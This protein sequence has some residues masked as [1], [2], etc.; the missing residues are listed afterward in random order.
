MCK[1]FLNDFFN[2][3]CVRNSKLKI[4]TMKTYIVIFAAQTRLEVD[5]TQHQRKL[6]PGVDAGISLLM[7]P[8]I[9]LILKYPGFTISSKT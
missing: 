6:N 7:S 4:Q 3:I 2:M 1:Q 9:Q 8:S 5:K